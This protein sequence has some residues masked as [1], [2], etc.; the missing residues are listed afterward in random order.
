MGAAE[1]LAAGISCPPV[2]GGSMYQREANSDW[3]QVRRRHNRKKQSYAENSTSNPQEIEGTARSCQC[4]GE[5][6]AEFEGHGEPKRN[7]L[8]GHIEESVHGA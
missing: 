5:W 8:Q 2:V 6:T 3:I 4:N 7:A 1:V